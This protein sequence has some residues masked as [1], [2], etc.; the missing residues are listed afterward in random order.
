ML[1]KFFV[2]LIFTG[3][4]VL[5]ASLLLRNWI[6][7]RR[8]PPPRAPLRAPAAGEQPDIVI[9]GINLHKA[10]DRP[11]L[12]G[13]NVQVHQGETLGVLGRSG[14]GKSVL[15]KLLAGFLKPDRG[16]ILYKGR[17]ITR[18]DE[19]QLLEFRK[20]VS[21]VFQGGAFFDFLN[22]REN[23]A[24]PLR[25]QGITDEDLIRERVDYLLEAVEL[26][27]MGDLTYDELSTGAKKQ[28]AIARAI[29][30]NPEVILYDEPTTGVDPIIGKS[31][32]RLI[33]KLDTQEHFTSVVV[34]HDLK[35]LE[36]V[37]DRII[38]LK[39]GHIHFE[40]GIEDFR[41]SQDPFVVAFRTG[42]RIEGAE[43]TE[44]EGRQ[45]AAADASG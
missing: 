3:Y 11:V 44:L 41:N 35:C 19:S 4:L 18:M 45:P 22:V 7:R 8:S 15:L 33:R 39:D 2:I 17:E 34:T 14:T 1:F 27:G 36:I 12:A 21:Y 29:A 13:I 5:V 28:V 32:S 37:A 26:E 43:E 20:E 16:M 31:L 40:G 42:K 6:R 24:Y 23:I 30:N 38:L 10:F 25:E 9:E